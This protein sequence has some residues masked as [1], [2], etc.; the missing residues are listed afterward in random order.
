MIRIGILEFGITCALVALAI[1]IPLLITRGYAR[2]NKRMKN[3][4][5]LLDKKEK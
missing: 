3:M 5:D 4:E 1:V 2:L